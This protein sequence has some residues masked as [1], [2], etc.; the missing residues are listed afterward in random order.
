MAF[1]DDGSGRARPGGNP[2]ST[3]APGRPGRRSWDSA[4]ATK[5]TLTRTTAGTQTTTFYFRRRFTV[6]DPSSVSSLTAKLVRDD[7]AMV[8]LNGRLVFRSNMPEGD[9]TTG[10][11]ASEVVG[12]VNESAFFEQAIDPAVLVAGQ[13]VLAV[14]VHQAN[15]NSSDVSFD[16]QLDARVS[17]SDRAPA[18]LRRT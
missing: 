13:N 6:A 15:A 1:L 3:K 12:D 18:R 5:T 7:G 4:T 9:V 14:E 11:L 8:Y 17:A 10:T 2:P 16:L